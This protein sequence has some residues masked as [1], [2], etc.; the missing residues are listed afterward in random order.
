MQQRLLLLVVV[1][2]LP[3]TLSALTRLKEHYS[4]KQ[5][6]FTWPTK[7][8]KERAIQSGMFQP[9]NVL[10]LGLEAG[11]DRLVITLPRWKP[12]L[13][14][15]L[16]TVPRNSNERAPLLRPYP[17]W[18]WHH[19][20]N[21]DGLISVFRVNL[22]TC[23]RLWVLDSGAVDAGI[24][25]KQ[26][27]PP[28][29][30]VFDFN[31]DNLLVKYVLPDDQVKDGSFFT[32]IVV[33][34]VNNDCGLDAYAYMSDVWRFGLVIYDLK[35]NTSRRI[36]HEYFYPDPMATKF[37]VNGLQFRWPDGIFGLALSPA[38]RFTNEKTLYFHPMAS[39]REFAVSTEVLRNSSAN[40]DEIADMFH[41]FDPRG[42]A[43]EH[44]SAE[45]MSANGVLFYNLVSRNAVGCW[46][47][48]LPYK[49]EYQGIVDSDNE[50]LVF[51]N[52]M[53]IDKSQNLWVL[54][55]R[56][57]QFIYQG[58]NTSDVNFR[59]LTGSVMDL[60]RDGVCDP[61]TMPEVKKNKV[62]L[63]RGLFAAQFGCNLIGS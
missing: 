9:E 31:T 6:D 33:D 1:T 30:L 45:A 28:K 23:N 26:Q 59:V 42:T 44:S 16:A 20:G 46:N 43:N 38:S 52:D 13:P 19:P 24:G 5:V 39:F 3:C 53:R 61:R 2:L 60:V 35:T 51:P 36:E 54:S 34:L 22:D 17:N 49:P 10:P 15:T 25:V 62:S 12:G 57:P 55:N 47:S 29:L 32:N 27:C 8:L 41:A 4:W 56:L 18:I 14:A 48:R 63:L 50:A 58:L 40:G 37:N 7:A 21:C 11:T